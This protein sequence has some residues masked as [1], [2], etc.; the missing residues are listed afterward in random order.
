MWGVQVP[1]NIKTFMW[2]LLQTR[3]PIKDRFARPN[4]I[5]EQ[6]NRCPFVKI[7][8]RVLVTSLYIAVK[9]ARYGT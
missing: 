2:L 8:E 3:T 7:M 6:S 1:P 9:S 5:A 4:I